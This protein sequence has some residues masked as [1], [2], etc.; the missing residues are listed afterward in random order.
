MLHTSFIVLWPISPAAGSS[1]IRSSPII[2][3]TIN[4]DDNDSK[5]MMIHALGHS[6]NERTKYLL[7]EH[8]LE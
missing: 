8:D 5:Q 4:M 3:E 6:I 2:L 1:S 7:P